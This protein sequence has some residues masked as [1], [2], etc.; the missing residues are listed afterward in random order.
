M[1]MQSSFT[2]PDQKPEARNNL[3]G[4]WYS[5]SLPPDPPPEASFKQR[6][7]IRRA[8]LASI[9]L[10]WFIL[11]LI[12]VLI[13]FAVTNPLSP[14]TI[15]LLV[16]FVLMLT[17]VLLN[18]HGKVNVVGFMMSA[19]ITLVIWG[20]ILSNRGGLAPEN[21]GLFDLLVYPE[22]F[23]ATLLPI[24]WVF[25]WALANSTFVALTFLYAPHTPLMAQLL[26]TSKASIIERP[27]QVQ[28]LVS[29][30]LWLWVRNATNALRRAD[31]AEELSKLQQVVANQMLEKVNQKRQLDAEIQHIELILDQSASGNLDVRASQQSGH[32]LWSISGKLNNLLS[33]F[34]RAVRD[35]RQAQQVVSQFERFY[36]AEQRYQR[37]VHDV[38]ALTHTIQQAQI[39]HQPLHLTR[40]GTPLD[41]LLQSINGKYISEQSSE[42]FS[43]SPLG[44]PDT[45]PLLNGEKRDDNT[46]EEKGQPEFSGDALYY[47]RPNGSSGFRWGD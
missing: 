32:M 15:G 18:R 2:A 8:H 31:R 14:S 21:L 19:G 37:L 35:Y 43:T 25:A 7:M 3:L 33:R 16:L 36:L 39:R 23:A 22:L 29:V 9:L 10:F 41:L 44:P 20:I 47:R 45:S 6:E 24:N 12:A 5:L 27:I 28:I 26:S 11:V 38:S 4:W 17:A 34:R 40:T 30:V 42:P 1:N 13:V 46:D